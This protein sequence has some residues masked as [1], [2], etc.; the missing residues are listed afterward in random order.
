M[1]GP[2]NGVY[3]RGKLTA[4]NDT[5]ELPE[6]WTKL[7]DPDSITIQLT[8]I[9]KHQD[10]YVKDISNNCVFVGGLEGSCFYVIFAERVD[11]PKLEVEID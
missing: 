4:P 1:E 9:G 5:I 11:V 8:S 10:L 6:Y 2:E 3:L 7:V